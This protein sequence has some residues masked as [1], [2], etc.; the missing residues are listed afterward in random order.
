MWFLQEEY[1]IT[2]NNFRRLFKAFYVQNFLFYQESWA[3]PDKIAAGICLC[4]IDTVQ[5]ACNFIQGFPVSAGGPGNV[6]V[7]QS[8]SK[9]GQL[10]VFFRGGGFIQPFLLDVLCEI[11]QKDISESAVDQTVKELPVFI[12]VFKTVEHMGPVI[13]DAFELLLAVLFFIFDENVP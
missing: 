13:V 1:S 9:A 10:V 6:N 4:A 3:D 8:T 7:V 12:P 2:G 5:Y 11:I